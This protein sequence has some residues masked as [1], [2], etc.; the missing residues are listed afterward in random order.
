VRGYPVDPVFDPG[1][2][3]DVSFPAFAVWLAIAKVVGE[4]DAGGGVRLAKAIDG[5]DVVIVVSDDEVSG[6]S[7]TP[8]EASQ[9][10]RYRVVS[11]SAGAAVRTDASSMAVAG[12]RRLMNGDLLALRG[13]AV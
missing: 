5:Q 10:P 1:G 12:I 2:T 9:R 13:R 6:L 11:A 4:V 8:A 3:L 7:A